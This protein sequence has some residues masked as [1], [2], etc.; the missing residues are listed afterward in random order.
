MPTPAT[1]PSSRSRAP[2]PDKALLTAWLLLMLGEAE[3][4]GWALFGDLRD[5][6]VVIEQSLAYR[7]LRELERDGLV[8]S[9]WTTSEAGPQRRL[10]RVTRAGNRALTEHAATVRESWE[11]HDAFVRARHDRDLVPAA[12]AAPGVRED[13][14]PAARPGPELRAAW[15]LLL[16]MSSA[17][18]GYELRQELDA[19]DIRIDPATLYRLL[20]KLERS[21]W[22]ESRWMNPSAGPRRRLYR[23]TTAGRRNLEQLTALITAGRDAHRAFLDAYEAAATRSA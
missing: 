2:H 23:V 6:G 11:L 18:Y 5:R 4:Y 8:T 10:Y 15:L 12:R 1:S 20:R 9:R 19:R 7:D 16:L 14:R 13:D 17:S 21:R 22:L 3:S